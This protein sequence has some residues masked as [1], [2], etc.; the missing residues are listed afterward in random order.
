MTTATTPTLS[1]PK[2]SR[3]Q[4]TLDYVLLMKPRVVVMVLA[5]TAASFYL[6]AVGPPHWGLLFHLLL[7]MTF[8][9]GGTLALNQYL[10]RVQDALMVRTQHRPV[11][12]GRLQP[13]AALWF[14]ILATAGGVLYVFL[15]V[16]TLSALVTLVTVGTYLFWYTPLKQ[17]SVHCLV[18]GAI[19]GA[20]PP[21]AGWAAARGMLDG[22]G[23]ILFAMLFLWQLPHSLAIAWLYRDD[24]ARAGFRLL[25]VLEPDG[26]RTARQILVS[27]SLLL[28]IGILP[29][30]VGLTGLLY[31]SVA[32]VLGLL[33]LVCGAQVAWSRT[34][35]TVRRL[36]LVS[37]VYLPLLLLS[38]MLDKIAA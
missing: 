30:L 18:V 1:L 11:P 4:R 2:L 8:A 26:S 16:Q 25:P 21:M 29:T 32:I 33:F 7:G 28:L 12:G 34:P 10:E 23:W 27:C 14:G 17:R 35:S 36:R 6:G 3:R 38:M 13:Q 24:Y 31:L 9:T 19:P 22:E 20:L 37:L 15:M 5:V